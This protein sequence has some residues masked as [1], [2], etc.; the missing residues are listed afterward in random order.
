[1]WVGFSCGVGGG[2]SCAFSPCVHCSRV[3]YLLIWKWGAKKC[4]L[5]R[6]CIPMCDMKHFHVRVLAWFIGLFVYFRSES[7]CIST[8]VQPMSQY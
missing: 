2:R 6:F 1:L 4:L 3:W 8:S 7:I 5:V